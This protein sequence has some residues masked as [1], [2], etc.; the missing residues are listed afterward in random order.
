MRVFKSVLVVV[1]FLLINNEMQGQNLFFPAKAGIVLTYVQKDA[2]G[3]TD[4][5]LRYT[6]T[7]VEGTEL[8]G[9]VSYSVEVLDKNKKSTSNP[10]PLKVEIK[11]GVMF[12]DM[13]QMFVGLP[14]DEQIE[15]EI[16]GVPMELPNNLQSGQTLKDAEMTMTMN[17]GFMKMSTLIKMT[18]RK[19]L[20]IEDVAVDAGTFK[21]HKITQNMSTTMME[22][23]IG[24]RSLSWFAFGIGI[25]KSETYDDKGKL[26]SSMELIE[27]KM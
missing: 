16:T 12:L 9:S 21:C 13:K 1:S 24:S 19:C 18:D 27:V 4:S 26:L 3:K 14:T 2:K 11:D 5:Y 15:V 7:A 6:I 23:E 20:A 10:I 22:R 25:V 8:N 17:M